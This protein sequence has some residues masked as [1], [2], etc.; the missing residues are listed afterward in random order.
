MVHSKLTQFGFEFGPLVVNRT[1]CD[2]KFGWV[3]VQVQVPNKKQSLQIYA[4]KTG[5]ITITSPEG[6]WVFHKY[7]DKE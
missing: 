7:I 2:D 6:E 1:C 4:T 5:K 3:V